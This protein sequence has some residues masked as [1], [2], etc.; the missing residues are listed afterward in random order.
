MQKV[1]VHSIP[2]ITQN[3]RI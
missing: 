2:K 3:G 1:Y